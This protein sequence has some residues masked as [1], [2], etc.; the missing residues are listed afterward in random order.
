MFFVGLFVFYPKVTLKAFS[1]TSLFDKS[2]VN[3]E[4]EKE[5][6]SVP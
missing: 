4:S 2:V 1:S 3:E 5:R 6:G